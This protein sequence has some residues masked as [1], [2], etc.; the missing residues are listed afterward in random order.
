MR[1]DDLF[2]QI[3]EKV[4]LSRT[5]RDLVRDRGAVVQRLLAESGPTIC[6][7][8]VGSMTRS[9]AIRKF[10][11]VD[12]LAVVGESIDPPTGNPA[13]LLAQLAGSLRELDA[14]V[15][16]GNMVVSLAFERPPAVEVIAAVRD[17]DG[18][19]GRYWIADNSGNSW[20]SYSPTMLNELTTERVGVLGPRFIKLIRVAKYWNRANSVGL[21]SSDIEEL[22]CYALSA[23]LSMPSYLRA[24]SE[25]LEVVLAW[26][27]G[28]P[29]AV[30][31][32][33]RTFLRSSAYSGTVDALNEVRA[34]L[35]NVQA[36]VEA[37]DGIVADMEEVASVWRAILGPD[38]TVNIRSSECD[39]PRAV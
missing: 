27:T 37:Q 3:D 25:L 16:V 22:A 14:Q 34:T 35:T 19:T 1:V 36:L 38:A 23:R 18:S 7:L 29:E 31:R 32:M 10:S 6:S 11:D 20:Q 8:L 12:I 39:R 15:S 2:E 17:S 13:T 9:T 28:N 26:V 33:G 5:E 30:A 4:R 21:Q 24:L